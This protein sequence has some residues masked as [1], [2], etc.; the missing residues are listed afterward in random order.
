[1]RTRVTTPAGLMSRFVRSRSGSSAVEFA[2]VA[3]P[4]LMLVL[5]IIQIGLFYLSQ[6]SLDTGVIKTAETL[7]NNF[8]TGTSAVLPDAATLKAS[9]ATSGGGMI[10]N[11]PNLLVEV[12]QFSTLSAAVLPIV[13]GTTDYGNKT[14]T[15]VLR[16]QATVP[17]LAPG[18]GG[19]TTI[20][21]SAMVRRQ[22]T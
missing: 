21:A 10:A 7:R 13:D 14:S 9:V 15:L 18:L 12:R 11:N 4:M 20:R 3:T 2:I 19:L 17:T 5:G 1:M 8:T 16:A 6:S 22:G